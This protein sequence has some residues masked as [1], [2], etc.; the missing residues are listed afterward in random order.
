MQ[1]WGWVN[2]GWSLRQ[3]RG[4]KS[5]PAA[6]QTLGQRGSLAPRGTSRDV[7]VCVCVCREWMG[8]PGNRA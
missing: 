7:C 5:A 1:V 6:G 4:K 2:R 3:H 8:D